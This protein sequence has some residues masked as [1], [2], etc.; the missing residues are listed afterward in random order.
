M[1]DLQPPSQPPALSRVADAFVEDGGVADGRP[2]GSWAALQLDRRHVGTAIVQNK[3]L[4]R[5]VSS[6]AYAIYVPLTSCGC[7]TASALVGFI[8]PDLVSSDAAVTPALGVAVVLNL[9]I[10][11]GLECMQMRARL[12]RH[13]LCQGQTWFLIGNLLLFVGSGSYARLHSG[14]E[15]VVWVASLYAQAFG[16]ILYLIVMDARVDLR[17][18][19]RLAFLTSA[20]LVCGFI[21]VVDWFAPAGYIPRVPLCIPTACSDT[22]A[23]FTSATRSLGF[24]FGTFV[25]GLARHKR[26]CASIAIACEFSDDVDPNSGPSPVQPT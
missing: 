5:L 23:A 21:L 14:E 2:S 22:R 20:T 4:A 19:T 16:C 7:L 13:I 24:F 6:R 1:H 17:R 3:H 8:A 10:L 15:S 26:W 9:A 12:L 25:L 18:P 11:L